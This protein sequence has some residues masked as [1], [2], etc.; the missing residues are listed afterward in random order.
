MQAVEEDPTTQELRTLQSQRE[1]EERERAGQAI[2]EED[3]QTHQRRADKAD[4]LRRK[5][6]ERADAER[7]G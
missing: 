2:S 6:A 5:L 4:Y 3:T 1:A 7:D